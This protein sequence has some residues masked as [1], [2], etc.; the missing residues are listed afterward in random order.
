MLELFNSTMCRE[1]LQR[2]YESVARHPIPTAI[3]LRDLCDHAI[4]K[5]QKINLENPRSYKSRLHEDALSN[6]YSFKSRSV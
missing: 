4:Q 6:E 3:E 1:T 2:E 5:S